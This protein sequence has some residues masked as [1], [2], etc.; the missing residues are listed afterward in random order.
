MKTTL[1]L[2]TALLL[3][4]LA[5]LH[6]AAAL[7]T[8]KP[9][10]IF[11]LADDLGIGNIGC[12]GSDNYKSPNIDKLA[13]TGTRFTQSFTGA[14]CGPSRALIMTGRYAFRNGSSNQDACMVMPNSELQL[15]RVLK[16]AGYATSFIGKWGQLPGDPDAAGFDDYLRFKGSGVYW[17]KKAGKA[18]AYHVNGKE[19]KL[20]DKEYMPDLMHERVATFLRANQTKPFFLYY[21]MVHVHGEIQPTPD[22]APDSKDL[23]GD[24][25]RYMDK[26]VGKLVAELEA[27][28]LR[29]NTLIIFMGD[30]G[31][32]K[33]QSLLSTI[34]SRN[35]SGMKG[36]MLECGGLVPTIANWPG[37]VPAGKVSTDLIDSTDWL[38]T[39]AELSGGKLPEKT[40]FDGR[41]FAPQLRGEPGT[42]REW[43]YN[44]LA[45]MWYVREAGWKLNE[46]GELYDMSDAPFT[47]KLVAASADT[48]ASKAARTRL[49]VA[50]AKLNPA[51]GI[52]DK[53]DGTGRHANK[54]KKKKSGGPPKPST[55]PSTNS[56]AAV[57]PSATALHAADSEELFV[58]RIVPLL[59]EK[60]LACHGQDAAKIKGG[61]DMRTR[62]STLKGGDSKKPGFI[63]GKPKESPL[64][65][66]VTRTHDDWEA[67]PPKEADKLSPEQIGWIKD[68]IAGGAPWPDVARVKELTKA[69]EAKWSAEDGIVV[70]TSGGLDAEWTNRKYKP[71]GLWAYQSVKKP[72]PPA[73]NGNPIDAFIA[74]KLPT[75]LAPAAAADRVTLIRR[76]TFDLI[77]LPPKPEDVEAFVKD[78]RT[79]DQAF[80]A[81]VERLL[82]S[83]HYG[84]RMAQHW[85]DV[86]RYADSSGFA[87]DYERG[88]AWRYRDYV[89][90]AFNSDKPYDQFIKEQIAGDEIDPSDPEK[91]IATGFLRMGPWELTGMEVE[92]I[93]RQRFLDDVVNSA[94][95]T[96]LAH[97]LQCAR[98]HDHKFDPVPTRDYYSIQA[99]FATTQ[100]SE[101]AAPFLPVENTKGFEE[102]AYLEK[103]LV[104]HETALSKLDAVLLENAQRWFK[105]NGKN[106]AQWNAAV[107]AAR[108]L[109]APK[110]APARKFGQYSDLFT[111]ARNAL[112]NARVPEA[113]FP[114]KLVGFTPEQF[115]LERVARK[116]LERL[117]WELDRY[118]PYALAVYGGRT[119][120]YKTV[121]AP[122]RMPADRMTTGELEETT[123]LTGGDPFGAGEKVKPGVL[124]VIGSAQKTPIPDT[125]EGR[126]KAFAE[127]V[128]SAENPLTTRAIVNRIWLW[129]FDHPLAGNPNNFGSTGKKPTHPELL[130]W[131]AATF[132]EKG[133]SFKSMHR[134][135]MN[136]EAYRRS[137]THLDLKTLAE[138]DPTGASYAV[139][140][141]RRLTAE[142]LRDAMLTA[143]GELNP[144]L[145]GIP[146]RPEINLE[147]ALQ[148]RQ[149]MGT[150]ASAWT[151]N[152]KPEQRHRRSLYALK[153]RGLPDPSQ[154]VFNAPTPDFSCERREASTVTPQVF[155]LF[156][157]QSTHS[158]ALAL[159]NRAVKETKS[160]EAAITRCFQLAFSRA[161]RA[162]ELQA[163]LA[164]WRE[165][166]A[167]LGEAKPSARK[168]PLEVRRDA[169]EENTGEK[170]SFNE[171]LHAYA[172]FVAD[173]QTADVP[174]HTRALADVCLVL[175]NSNEFAYV[176]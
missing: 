97:S 102:R 7:P 3:A 115:G 2:L 51:G 92:K 18:E 126:R 148:P 16:S 45:A 33:G 35:L 58:R 34:A 175:L 170:F 118:E 169:V 30:N 136:S 81:V 107:E 130:D 82:G 13:A 71:E 57:N 166:E 105:A 68:W 174:A 109:S 83:S 100:L 52:P 164:H 129:H 54:D 15:G 172:D 158:R 173:L 113:D 75:G 127:W 147:A 86:T 79:V 104:E 31:T 60:C 167:L 157:G 128:A 17:N 77:G 53:G 123:V 176:Y 10:I 161:P 89:V 94:G 168:P 155:S 72:M 90:R 142:E 91:I 149:V 152:P 141:P 47:E 20:G 9:N 78:A 159:A 150:F 101:R 65:L 32:G 93:A 120:E 66:A 69:N 56:G 121:F 98:C 36:S 116:G 110:R 146:N 59:H 12:Y 138:K 74:S 55:P 21:S 11:I 8:S 163:C 43:I 111:T 151:P 39:F 96:F 1:L 42:K 48:A 160:D 131:L 153:I 135:I 46:K 112:T 76:A 22:S 5:A 63:G 165:I 132:V 117:R 49:T 156:N 85:Q 40:I 143:T 145:G 125:I 108:N 38:S 73:R 133:W 122:L 24:N 27:L 95:E 171:K 62:A 44:Q 4:P 139:F 64:Y 19:L 88:N 41:S 23:F 87:N 61:L 25:I 140:K 26:L 144:T 134:L 6:A 106:P 28:K 67:M 29:D 154:E 70:K 114:P 162:G 103:Q 99:V 14:L 137:A 84:E 37:K 119:R 80:A 50:L 124:S